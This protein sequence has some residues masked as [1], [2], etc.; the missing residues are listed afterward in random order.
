MTEPRALRERHDVVL[1]AVAL[2]HEIAH[3]HPSADPARWLRAATPLVDK[4][5]AGL[6]LWPSE[7]RRLAI[8][9]DG[10]LAAAQSAQQ[11]HARL[12]ALLA[13]HSAVFDGCRRRL[14]RLQR[15]RRGGRAA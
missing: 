15:E 9:H 12:Q 11:R 2:A 10:A 5:R 6:I 4:L 1:D 13:A 3:P 8:L 14:Q 7:R